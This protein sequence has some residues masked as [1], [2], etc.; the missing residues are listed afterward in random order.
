MRLCSMPVFV[1]WSVLCSPTSAD[2]VLR[3]G[4]VLTGPVD[5]VSA[6]GVTIGGEASRTIGWDVVYFVAGEHSTEAEEYRAWSDTVWRAKTRLSR[7]DLMLA[8]PMFD[9]LFERVE[10]DGIGGPTGLL[11][12]EGALRC[13][14]ANSDHGGA[15]D[16]WIYALAIRETGQRLSGESATSGV[17][18]AQTMLV[19]SLPPIWL[20]DSEDARRLMR[21]PF[22][23]PGAGASPIDGLIYL[24]QRSAAQSLGVA[25]S[26]R[27][28]FGTVRMGPG[29]SI[30]ASISQSQSVEPSERRAAR[31]ELQ[32]LIDQHPGTWKEAW[33][34]V[35]IGRSLLRESS[36]AERDRGMLHLLHA[37]A[38]FSRSQPHLSAIALAEVGRE[39]IRRGDHTTADQIRAE[40]A[41]RYSKHPAG[42]WLDRH[43]SSD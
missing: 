13:R 8:S 19:P 14:V 3:N 27:R 5:A 23:E 20:E 32:L 21:L 36:D 35:A 30:V 17:I 7:G 12:A 41:E 31:E 1:L 38:R 15:V 33:A 43:V 29:A 28:D 2:V 22:E 40:L 24:Y 26:G 37:P 6:A 10:R 11:V 39:A 25:F 42:A 9:D 18:D 34:R 4:Q 16:A